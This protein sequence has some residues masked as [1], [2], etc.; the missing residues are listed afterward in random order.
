MKKAGRFWAHSPLSVYAL[1]EPVSLTARVADPVVPE[2]KFPQLSQIFL[3]TN[4][5]EI[6]SASLEVSKSNRS[7]KVRCF[8][9]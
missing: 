1:E 5:S 9:S 3:S 2:E 8:V 7:L 6:A 4:G